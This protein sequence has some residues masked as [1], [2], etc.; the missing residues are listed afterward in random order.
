MQRPLPSVE[1]GEC[2]AFESRYR[3]KRPVILPCTIPENIEELLQAEDVSL[4]EVDVLVSLDNRRFLKHELTRIVRMSLR[5]GIRTALSPTQTPTGFERRYLRQYLDSSAPASWVRAFEPCLG[6][7]QET[8]S[9]IEFSRKNVG[10]WCSSGGSETPL[11][12]DLCHGLLVQLR[13]E[14]TFTLAPPSDT[15]YMYWD[16]PKHQ[17]TTSQNKT[18]SPIDL[19]LWLRGDPS[20]RQQFPDTEY[21]AFSVAHLKPGDALYTPPG[22]WHA[23]SSD[24]ASG[25]VSLLAP[26][27]PKE[28]EEM[29]PFNV[30]SV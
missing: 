28:D 16:H 23:V 19:P 24:S 17:Q 5:E 13:G 26:W 11:H 2:S 4:Q 29:L 8:V 12:F 7:L 15:P 10:V 20:Q 1:R 6:L 25:S 30:L 14:K 22:W 18:T 27:D 3:S 21:C 9:G